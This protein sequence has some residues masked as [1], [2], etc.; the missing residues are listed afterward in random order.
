MPCALPGN[1]RTNETNET[2]TESLNAAVKAL[3]EKERKR[4]AEQEDL[5]KKLQALQAAAADK[6]TRDVIFEVLSNILK[7]PV[8]KKKVD[9]EVTSVRNLL[10]KMIADK[11][12]EA[13]PSTPNH[14]K[15]GCCGTV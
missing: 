15:V 7:A 1:H 5:T 12:D 6:S 9:A 13:V 14:T 11:V 10:N 2:N 4:D 3:E 8:A